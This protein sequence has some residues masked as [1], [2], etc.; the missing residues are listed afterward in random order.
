[1]R[2]LK[3][4]KMIAKSLRK[5]RLDSQMPLEVVIE[6]LKDL[7]VKCSRANLNKVEIGQISCR[8]DI[9]AALCLIYD[10]KVEEV[11]YKN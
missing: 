8:A 7:K 9:L 11:L 10:I 3:T 5:A 1:M 2:R 6:D 4:Q